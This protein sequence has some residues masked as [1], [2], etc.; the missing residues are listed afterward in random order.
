LRLLQNN[1]TAFAQKWR[2]S[3]NTCIVVKKEFVME[4]ILDIKQL[5]SSIM[6]GK[7][8]DVELRSMA[9]AIRFAQSEIRKKVKRQLDVGVQVRWVSP[10]NPW[11]ATGKVTKVA[12]KYVT[13]R[14]DKDSTLWKIP[15]NMLEVIP[16]Q[17]EAV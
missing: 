5:N 9:D 14:N 4:R 8:T 13:V 6:Y 16:G 11:G 3:Y 1:N 7:W 15:A 2:F 10:K 12:L 17:M